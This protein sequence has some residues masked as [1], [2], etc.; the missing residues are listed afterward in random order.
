MTER[1]RLALLIAASDR[2]R[3]AQKA[4]FKMRSVDSLEA[5]KEAEKAFDRTLEEVRRSDQQ[6]KLF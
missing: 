1:E 2:L 3:L 6:A 4:Y 5:A